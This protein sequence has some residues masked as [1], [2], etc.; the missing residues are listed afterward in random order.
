MYFFLMTE[1]L[2]Y[3]FIL[4]T[5]CSII[6]QL[7]IVLDKQVVML[8]TKNSPYSHTL[9]HFDYPFMY[10]YVPS[11]LLSHQEWQQYYLISLMC[12]NIAATLILLDW[13]PPIVFNVLCS[14]VY[15]TVLT[16]GHVV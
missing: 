10:G 15:L 3:T 6:V 5:H 9:G 8:W 11:H 4:K 7:W 12:V 13:S 2:V 14:Y 16:T 1:H